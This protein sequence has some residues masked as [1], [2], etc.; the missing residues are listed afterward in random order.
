MAMTTDTQSSQGLLGDTSECS[1]SQFRQGEP[2]ARDA[3]EGASS[4]D[5]L[6]K[7]RIRQRKEC[8][9]RSN[10]PVHPLSQLQEL[11]PACSTSSHTVPGDAAQKLRIDRKE[12]AALYRVSIKTLSHNKSVYIGGKFQRYFGIWY[13]ISVG[14]CLSCSVVPWL[15]RLQY[16]T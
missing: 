8:H 5:A 4:K 14:H 2:R 7:H 15:Q 9:R 16:I 1:I 11:N 13:H 6:E 12:A 10:P 3:G